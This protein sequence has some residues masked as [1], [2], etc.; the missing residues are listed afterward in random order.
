[1]TPPDEAA[2][3]LRELRS[4]TAV[5]A[6]SVAARVLE[7]AA[8]AAVYML[9]GRLGQAIAVQQV[10]A[11]FPPAGI[12]LAALLVRGR[13]IAPGIWVG[14]FLLNA[15]YLHAASP[16]IALPVAAG[17]AL[18]ATA[19]PLVGHAL[20]TRYAG[21]ARCVERTEGVL[22]FVVL[23]GMAPAAVAATVGVTS[24]AVAGIQAVRPAPARS[25]S[26]P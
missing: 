8:L 7:A 24:L 21:G 15:S 25:S 12:A 3:D 23:G 20:V 6:R 26:A 18:G 11:V 14:S 19:G 10:T 16:A 4:P 22:R 17:M 1:M 5:M 13:A 2:R 9:L